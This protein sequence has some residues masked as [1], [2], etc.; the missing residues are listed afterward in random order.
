M[1]ALYK[2]AGLCY[3][4]KKRQAGKFAAAYIKK[5][6]VGAMQGDIELKLKSVIMD[7]MAVIRALKRISHEILE[8][9]H[10]CAD[11]CL[12]GICSRGVPL[13]KI[14]AENIFCI[15]GV[16]VDVGAL[17]T[18]PYRDDTYE[19]LPHADG[20]QTD[21][22]FQIKGKTIVLVDDVLYTGR[23][24]RAAID[25]LIEL[26][27]PERVQLA[28]LIDR[29]HRELPI[30]GDYIG[31]NVPTSRLERIVVKNKEH[32]GALAVELYE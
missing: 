16:R 26:G 7:D 5:A 21:I 31:K 4:T 9:N 23:T 14:I 3:Y 18:T 13:A 6:R 12:I 24:V 20:R 11:L 28:V 10:G 19:A 15:E 30:R 25:A 29:G 32:D 17:D 27:R 22:S 1:Q 8:R 2:F